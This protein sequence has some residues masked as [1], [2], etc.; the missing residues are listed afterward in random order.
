MEEKNKGKAK[1]EVDETLGDF[2]KYTANLL[3]IEITIVAV[4][5]GFFLFIMQKQ[6]A[7]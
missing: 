1:F 2:R 5:I 7:K 4:T 3:E 6:F